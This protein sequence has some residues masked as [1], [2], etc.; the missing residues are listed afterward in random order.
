[1][2]PGECAP[3]ESYCS[4]TRGTEPLEFGNPLPL[5]GFLFDSY[6]CFE[7]PEGCDP[8]SCET[9]FVT[10]SCADEACTNCPNG[11]PVFA[12]WGQCEKNETSGLLFIYVWLE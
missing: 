12:P 4:F 6:A 1:M 9:C 10:C 8:S 3:E 2:T 11:E 7:L 5:P